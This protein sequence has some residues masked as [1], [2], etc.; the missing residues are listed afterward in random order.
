MKISSPVVMVKLMYF[1]TA[2]SKRLL[3]EKT[4]EL[5]RSS[6]STREVKT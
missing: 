3:G 5:N 1:R 2:P 4:D 6:L